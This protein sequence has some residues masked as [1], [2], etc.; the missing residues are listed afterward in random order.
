MELI[1]RG[2]EPDLAT[3]RLDARKAF[4]IMISGGV[5]V[6]PLS[7]SYAIFAN[8]AHGVERIYKLKNRPQ[9]KPNG[10]IGNW[11]IFSDVFQTESRDRDLVRCLTLDNDLPLSVVAPFNPHHDWLRTVEFGA[12]RRSTKALTMDL[13]MHAG[14]L[15]DELAR[16]SLESAKPLMGSSANLS[17][18]GSKFRLEDVQESLRQGCDL[19]LDYGTSRYINA[20]QMGS[21]I[22]ELPGWKILRWGGCFEEQ[23]RLVLKHFGVSLEPRPNSGPW[24]LV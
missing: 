24:T 15:H 2:A 18:S 20:M 4:Q 17:G 6:L 1:N 8:T 9:T 14:P 21:T 23:A 5:A 16:M 22:I 13:L 11:D 3:V 7:V 12:L 19:V 10:V